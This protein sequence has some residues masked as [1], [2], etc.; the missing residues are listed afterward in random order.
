MRMEYVAYTSLSKLLIG[1]IQITLR[2]KDLVKWCVA[3]LALSKTKLSP[4]LRRE[5]L[6]SLRPLWVKRQ[7]GTKWLKWRL[8][9]LYST[10][11]AAYIFLA[12]ANECEAYLY[13]IVI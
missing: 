3:A 6:W 5:P 8:L 2:L 11:K 4:G 9:S 13:K 7:V 1:I 10:Q 12:A